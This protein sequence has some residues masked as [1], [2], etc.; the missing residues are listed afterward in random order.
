VREDVT[1]VQ[2]LVLLVTLAPQVRLLA[3]DGVGDVCDVG[4]VRSAGDVGGAAGAMVL[5][6]L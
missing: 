5:M 1:A 3:F 4:D 6:S 2:S